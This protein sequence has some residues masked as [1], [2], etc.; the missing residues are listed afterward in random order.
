MLAAQQQQQLQLQLQLQLQVRCSNR[1]EH[2]RICELAARAG[3]DLAMVASAAAAVVGVQ[4]LQQQ[5]MQLAQAA[6][7]A[8]LSVPA[9]TSANMSATDRGVLIWNAQQMQMVAEHPAVLYR[10]QKL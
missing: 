8:G 2:Y 9:A 1:G 6:A 4:L 5:Q 10:P 7:A 3:A